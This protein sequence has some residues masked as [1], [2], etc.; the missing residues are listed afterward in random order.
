[1]DYK[2]YSDIYDKDIIVFL[3]KHFAWMS[4]ENDNKLY[5]WLNP[6]FHPWPTLEKPIDFEEKPYA[7]G[8]V[9]IEGNRVVGYLGMITSNRRFGDRFFVYGTPTTWAIDE[10]YRLFLPKATKVLLDN[11]DICADFT[12]RKSVEQIMCKLFKFKYC[13]T[14]EYRIFPVPNKSDFVDVIEINDA[15]ICYNTLIFNEYEDH[16]KASGFIVVK[17]ISKVDGD[18]GY[19]FLKR[20]EE[21]TK[22]LRVLK[23]VNTS[24]FANNCMEISWKLL[25]NAFY[26]RMSNTEAFVQIIKGK[27]GNVPLCMECDEMLLGEDKLNH[28]LIYEK[29][30]V[31]VLRSKVDCTISNVDFL[32]SEISNLSSKL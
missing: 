20:Y 4:R 32:Y 29:E 27:E 13:G 8:L 16:K 14:K 17:M 9:M 25:R 21:D 26:Q 11:L 24:L 3:K 23:I 5:E 7:R 30:V 18:L 6:I 12:P 2:P 31:R 22:R 1:M 28:P 15:N 10:P 19:L